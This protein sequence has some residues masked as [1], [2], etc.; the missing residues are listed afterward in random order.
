MGKHADQNVSKGVHAM[1]AYEYATA[2][3]RTGA[4]GF[5][6]A[7][8]GK[9]A[10]QVDTGEYYV[11]KDV[12]GGAPT[13]QG[14]SGATT[15]A[16]PQLI[17]ETQE[18]TTAGGTR[19]LGQFAFSASDWSDDSDFRFRACGKVSHAGLT[20]SAALYNLTD[21]E[22]VTGAAHTF[23]GTSFIASESVSLTG[24]T[25]AGN[26]KFDESIYEVR[27]QVIGGAGTTSI[28]YLGSSH[29]VA[30]GSAGDD[31]PKG[32]VYGCEVS[33]AS[34]STIQIGSGQ[35]RDDSDVFTMVVLSTLTVD[36]STPGAG[37]LDTGSEASDTWYYLWLIAKP[38]GTVAGLLSLSSTSP[39]MPSGYVYKKLFFV[40]RN[41]SSSNIIKFV[42]HGNGT[43]RDCEYDTAIGTDIMVSPITIETTYAGTDDIDFAHAV[44]PI[45]DEAYY[46]LAVT[47]GTT[48]EAANV[49]PKGAD[50][51][52]G[53]WIVWGGETG[54]GT[55]IYAWLRVGTNQILRAKMNSA[56]AL[57]AATFAV[58][59][60]RI[61]I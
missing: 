19:Y 8:I 30:T 58:H 7:D 15:V 60:W 51:S 55:A 28:G 46:Y 38:D 35:A 20:M 6:D 16:I 4:A 48:P 2:A 52:G 12:A 27:A 61:S 54:H 26:I 43:Q 39:T 41:N 10:R 34:A 14:V 31:V 53:G 57:N 50:E 1:H 44:P 40:V 56:Q 36:I 9:V 33:W 45:A 29:I 25:N 13:W 24:G 3:A 49:L 21:S 17:T 32:Y 11:L 37:G 47:M 59:K 42:C 18:M 5:I 22:Y 23:T